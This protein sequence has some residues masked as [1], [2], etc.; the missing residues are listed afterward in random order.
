MPELWKRAS[1]GHITSYKPLSFVAWWQWFS[2]TALPQKPA[3]DSPSHIQGLMQNACGHSSIFVWFFSPWVFL[4]FISWFS[5][6]LPNFI[7]NYVYVWVCMCGY[8][9]VQVSVEAKVSESPGTGV[10]GNYELPHMGTG[11]WAPILY[12]SSVQCAKTSIKPLS[13]LCE[14]SSYVAQTYYVARW[15]WVPDSSTS[16]SQC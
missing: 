6:V 14:T 12:K 1:H 16:A 2:P 10:K 5:F 3:S 15:P 13:S 7:F 9:W 8:T 11:N 4:S